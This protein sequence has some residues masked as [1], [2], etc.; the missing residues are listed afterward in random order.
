MVAERAGRTLKRTVL[1]L[2]GFNSMII[3]D[4]VDMG[5]A[6]RTATFGSFFHQ[7]QICLNTRRIIIQRKIYEEFL[8]KFAAR[9]NSPKLQSMQRET[10]H[11]RQHIDLTDP[12]SSRRFR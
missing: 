3:L 12:E 2:G 8:T 11:V 6:V 1:E 5:Y 10:R 4:D 9:T 7:G